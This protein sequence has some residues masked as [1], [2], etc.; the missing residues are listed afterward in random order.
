MFT[1]QLKG[2]ASFD[3][4]WHEQNQND[5]SFIYFLMWNPDARNQMKDT[6][7]KVKEKLAGE[8]NPK[9][10]PLSRLLEISLHH[11]PEAAKPTIEKIGYSTSA[12]NQ[13]LEALETGG[14][15]PLDLYLRYGTF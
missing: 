14:H 9:H 15:T 5:R 4:I 7:S 11:K 10:R 13:A 8:A 3:Y 6:V 12:I 2:G 1:D